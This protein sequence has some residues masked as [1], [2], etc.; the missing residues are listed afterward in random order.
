MFLF[1]LQRSLRHLITIVVPLIMET[2]NREYR[3]EQLITHTL[4]DRI[5]PSP[6]I[7]KQSLHRDRMNVHDACRP[8]QMTHLTFWLWTFHQLTALSK[9]I[10]SPSHQCRNYSHESSAFFFN[11]THGDRCQEAKLNHLSRL[12]NSM[13]PSWQMHVLARTIKTEKMQKRKS[14]IMKLTLNL[15][16]RQATL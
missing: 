5:N 2:L 8:V 3:V 6:E 14:T 7:I 13:R 10:F 9:Q 16:S 15:G 12:L 11:V 1:Y 4:V